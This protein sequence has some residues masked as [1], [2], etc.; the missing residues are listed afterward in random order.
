MDYTYHDCAKMI[1]H[2]LLNPA[3]GDAELEEGCGVAL[4]YDVAS[5]C[6]KPYYLHHADLAPGTSHFRT[7]IEAGQRIIC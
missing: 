1:D 4:A 2:S 6:I 3:L 7:T 5:V